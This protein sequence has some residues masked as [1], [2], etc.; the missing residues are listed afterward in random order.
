MKFVFWFYLQTLSET[1]IIL[2]RTE[3]VW[4]QTYIGLHVKYQFVL[5]YFSEAWI[6]STDFP[7]ILKY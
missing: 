7:K 2:R 3:K 1:F 4:S 5:S 6:F